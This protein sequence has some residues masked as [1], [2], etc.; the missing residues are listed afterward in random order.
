MTFSGFNRILLL[1]CGLFILVWLIPVLAHSE[2]SRAVERLEKIIEKPKAVRKSLKDQGLLLEATNTMDVLSNVSGGIR[3]KTTLTGDLDLLLTI[4]IKKLVPNWRGT[5]FLYGLGLYGNDPSK[6]VG[7]IQGV[8]N[9]AAPNTWKLFEAWYQHNLF[10][11]FSLL[12]GLY[13]ITS[14][15]DVIVSASTLFLNSSF[16]TG[17][18]LGAGGENNLSTF[19]AT[20][21]GVRAQ[22]ILTDSLMVRAVVA[23]GIPGNPNDARGTHV[24]LRKDDGLFGSMELAYYK[25]NMADLTQTKEKTLEELPR[26]LTFR[27]IGRSAPLVY[28]SK[29]ALGFWGYTTSLDQLNKVNSSG[30]PVKQHGTFGVYGL[31]EYDV[32]YEKDDKDQGLTLFA[33]AG[34]AD[35]NVNRISQYYG[36]GFIYKGLIPGRKIDRT[37]FGVA[38]AVN[39]HEYKQSQKR[40]GQ[41]VDNAEITLEGT[42]SIFVNSN[43][44]IQPDLQYVI[45]PGTVPGRQNA[46]ILGARLEV[47][48]N[49]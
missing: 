27:R 7:D 3:R 33:R 36:G 1:L 11:R 47:N 4:D 12:A 15:F 35:P 24:R 26:R 20:S 8:S 38:A 16:G 43:L 44:V 34:M 2:E 13:D 31:A 14:E 23:D 28:K 48:L 29:V 17:A 25:Y 32:Y 40:A 49:N 39:S 5:V 42:Y 18:E 19:P 10:Q 41:P 46:L 6:N 9:I 22:A 37:A 30:E 21:L 45:N